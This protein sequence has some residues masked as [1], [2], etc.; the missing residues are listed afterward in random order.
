MHVKKCTMVFDTYLLVL[1]NAHSEEQ[2]KNEITGM[3]VRGGGGGGTSSGGGEPK[4]F[5]VL[6]C[7]KISKCFH[8]SYWNEKREGKTEREINC[9]VFSFS[10]VGYIR[11]LSLVV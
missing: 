4:S 3:G 1:F 5:D 2:Q 9:W 11:L 6:M 7:K 10:V 8:V